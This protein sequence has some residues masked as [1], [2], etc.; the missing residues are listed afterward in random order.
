MSDRDAKLH[1]WKSKRAL[2][3]PQRVL[4]PSSISNSTAKRPKQIGARSGLLRDKS[5]SIAE[6]SFNEQVNERVN[7]VLYQTLDKVRSG[8]LS[9]VK[10]EKGFHIGFQQHLRQV[11]R[12]QAQLGHSKTKNADRMRRDSDDDEYNDEVEENLDVVLEHADSSLGKLQKETAG[13]MLLILNTGDEKA[14]LKLKGIGKKRAASIVQARSEHGP[15]K[16]LTDLSTARLSETQISSILRA[17]IL[18]DV[19]L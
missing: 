16:S 9:P 18:I 11:E 10:R 5:D 1:L 12:L 3:A 2:E 6:K 17:N 15:F 7:T 8:I 19:K 14:I 13:G 4:K